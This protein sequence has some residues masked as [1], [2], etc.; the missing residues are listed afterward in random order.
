MILPQ[1]IPGDNNGSVHVLILED[2]PMIAFG[3]EDILLDAGF[4]IAGVATK[5][6]AAMQPLSMLT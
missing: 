1:S 4:A 2:E 6:E 3:I 5:L